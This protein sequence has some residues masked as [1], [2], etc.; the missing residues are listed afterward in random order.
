MLVDM[1]E[2]VR[3][4]VEKYLNEGKVDGVLAL[5]R[6]DGHVGP[7]L[8]V[9][10][11]DIGILEIE[12]KHTLAGIAAIALTSG[13]KKIAI[14]GRGCDERTLVELVKRYQVTRTASSSSGLRAAPSRRRRAS[15]TARGRRR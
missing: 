15:A 7:H 14:I 5:K 10:G 4:L 8:F 3:K 2:K 6:E 12:P 13:V 9:K 11:D 1:I